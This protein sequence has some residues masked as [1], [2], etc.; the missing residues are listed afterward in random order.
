MAARKSR[1]N[2]T[3]TFN[4][5]ALTNYCNQND[6]DM[7]VD[8]IETTHLGSSGAESIAGD[9]EYTISVGG[10]WD[11]ALDTALA[12]EAITTGTKRTAVVTYVGSTG[13]VTYTWTANAEIA[14][15]K[16]SAKVGDKISWSGELALSGAPNRAAA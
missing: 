4:S 7:T 14:N 13:T 10:D 2:S 15:Y 16:I 8:R 11:T 5:V 1:G 3:V 6:L 9:T 12:P